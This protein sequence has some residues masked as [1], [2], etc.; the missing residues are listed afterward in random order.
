MRLPV[1]TLLVLTTFAGAA[2][3]DGIYRYTQKD[4]TVVY[5]NVAPHGFQ[6]KKVKGNFHP[7][8]PPEIAR[9]DDRPKAEPQLD[10]FIEDAARRYKV[11]VALVWAIMH[12]ESNFD[13]HAVSNKGAAGL[14]QLMP[15]TGSEM[16]V[17]DL[18]D[19]EQSIEGGT[20]YLRVLANQFDG[21]MVK[22][23]AAYNAG[24]EALKKYGGVPPFPE[25][26]AYVKRV[27]QLYYQYKQQ[28][29]KVAQGDGPAQPTQD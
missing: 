19:A 23:I 1:L 29:T 7:A 21:D 9:S 4:G 12:A 27:L 20:R 28:G 25:T 22:M 8:P 10:R 13:T 15:Q 16:Y 24:P 2:R 18:F 6:A 11:P 14:M 3:A 5:T 17:R 26:Q